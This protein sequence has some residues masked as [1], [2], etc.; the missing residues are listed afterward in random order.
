MEGFPT[1]IKASKA[2]F[3]TRPQDW[4]SGVSAGQM[5]PQCVL[6]SYLG[7]A[8]FPV[9]FRGVLILRR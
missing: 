1:E 4:P 3:F 2:M 9:F 8:I 5:I 7:L 6:W